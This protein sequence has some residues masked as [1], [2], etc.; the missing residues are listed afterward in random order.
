MNHVLETIIKKKIDKENKNQKEKKCR[1]YYNSNLS[2]MEFNLEAFC[3]QN[4]INLENIKEIGEEK[5]KD[6]LRRYFT[7]E[8]DG[9]LSK[10]DCVNLYKLLNDPW[11]NSKLER[12]EILASL[13]Y[14][15][16]KKNSIKF[17]KILIL[18]AG[19]GAEAKQLKSKY[20]EA[21][22]VVT[23]VCEQALKSFSLKYNEIGEY[24]IQVLNIFCI[25]SLSNFIKSYDNFDL[26]IASGVYRYAPNK[27]IK[28]QSAKTIFNY[29]TEP[30]GLFCVVEVCQDPKY[31]DP[32]VLRKEKPIYTHKTQTRTRINPTQFVIYKKPL[33]L[34]KV[35]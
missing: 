26:I 21:N 28:H 25:N 33:T 13:V 29:L 7:D 30:K 12:H 4:N 19:T 18:G 11:D 8:I 10:E 1:S 31:D 34:F 32:F 35:K 27:T 24:H 23:D 5:S 15:I 9:N 3:Q 2:L 17:K 22:I 20:P 16:G 14:S 6:L